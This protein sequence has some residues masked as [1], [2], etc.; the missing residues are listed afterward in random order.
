MAQ[1]L[2]R[3]PT[4]SFQGLAVGGEDICEGLFVKR[5]VEQKD[6]DSSQGGVTTLEELETEN[7]Q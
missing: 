2:W 1:E 6:T 7:A 5:N 4:A 3:L